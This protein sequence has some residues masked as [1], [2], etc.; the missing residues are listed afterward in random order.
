MWMSVYWRDRLAPI[1]WQQSSV[2]PFLAVG[3]PPIHCT[4]SR[5][6]LHQR[7]VPVTPL[8]LLHT[9]AYARHRICLVDLVLYSE[10]GTV[11][12]ALQ[13]DY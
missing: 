7:L 2:L 1:M 12:I 10:L 13:P 8:L 5:S 3:A 11:S 4:A 6:R 9:Q